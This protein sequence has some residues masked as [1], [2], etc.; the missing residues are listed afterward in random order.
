MV[1]SDV[2]VLKELLGSVYLTERQKQALG[3]VIGRVLEQMSLDTGALRAVAEDVKMPLAVRA[4]AEQ[5]LHYRESAVEE[6]RRHA[7]LGPCGAE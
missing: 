7:L 2:N 5:A 1:M 4:N 6:D 3:R